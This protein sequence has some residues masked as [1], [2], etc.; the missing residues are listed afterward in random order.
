M[1]DPAGPF[2]RL[3]EPV[4]MGGLQLRNR[5]M[6][7]A[8]E[9]ACPRTGICAISTSAS[10]EVALVGVHAAW[11]LSSFPPGPGTF[12]PDDLVEPDS[13]PPNP[14]TPTGRAYCERYVA[15]LERQAAVVHA[16]GAAV[17]RAAA[18]SGCERAR[19][20]SPGR[21]GAGPGRPTSSGAACRTVLTEAEIADLVQVFAETA[22]RV[23][24]AGL[25]H[26]GDPRRPRLPAGP[27]PSRRS[28]TPG[29]TGSG[30][31]STGGCS[32]CSMWSP[33]SVMRSVMPPGAPSLSAVRDFPARRRPRVGSRADMCEVAVRLQAA[34]VGRTSTSATAPLPDC[35]AAS[36]SAYVAPASVPGGPAVPGRRRRSAPRWTSRWW[37]P[38]GS[39]TPRRPSRSSGRQ[40]RHRGLPG[41]DRRPG[42]FFAKVQAGAARRIDAC[43]ACNECHIGVQV[44]CTVNTGGG[45][46]GELGTGHARARRR[47]PGDASGS[48]ARRRWRPG[49][50]GVSPGGAGRGHHVTL[51]ERADELGGA[52][53]ALGADPSRPSSTP[54]LAIVRT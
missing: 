25:D 24:R 10:R 52:L 17:R 28:P 43:I 34:G 37:S 44:R 6:M 39:P 46:R 42:Q 18:P 20:R 50:A 49:R 3:F 26:G 5:L 15:V 36:A 16:N 33:P 14:L 1:V 23:M 32:C 38:A 35:G 41:L 47:A 7:T 30:G 53:C 19:R 4:N 21:R 27:V 22:G 2:H 11:G 9:P 31:L 54:M 8:H 48:A 45:S 29:P 12:R 40:R 51:V 13:V